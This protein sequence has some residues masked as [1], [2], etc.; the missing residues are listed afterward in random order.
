LQH[1]ITDLDDHHARQFIRPGADFGLQ[2]QRHEGGLRTLSGIL[3]QSQQ[4]LPRLTPP[5]RELMGKHPVPPRDV[6]NPNAVPETLGHDPRLHLLR[7]F[8]IPP[9]PRDHRN[10]APKPILQFAI[11]VSF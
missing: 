7:P 1:D 5:I 4:T 3:G 11:A 6:N 8:P 10:A 2:R 9:S